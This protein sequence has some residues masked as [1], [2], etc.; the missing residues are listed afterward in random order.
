MN[1]HGEQTILKLNIHCNELVFFNLELFQII[2]SG[3][4][5]GIQK[6][7][8]Q[9][10]KE[11]GITFEKHIVASTTDD[12][13]VMCK[14]GFESSVNHVNRTIHL[15]VIDIFYSNSEKLIFHEEIYSDG[16]ILESYNNFDE[17]ENGDFFVE[18]YEQNH[19]LFC[20]KI[21]KMQL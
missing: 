13:T 4:T 12:I 19:Q 9:H 1:I 16:K 11:F 2:G 17:F 8:D 15:A 3:D 10:L 21:T 14:F 20:R 7:V 5:V 18:N 6:I